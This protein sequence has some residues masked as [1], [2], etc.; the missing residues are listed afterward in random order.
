LRRQRA[1]ISAG[2]YPFVNDFYAV[3]RADAPDGSPERILF[4]WIQTADGQAL[5]GNEG[6]ATVG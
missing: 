1:S 5:V 3:I 6:Y 4:D 2:D